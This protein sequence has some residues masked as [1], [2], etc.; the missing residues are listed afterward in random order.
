MDE[1][2]Y[3]KGGP[4]RLYTR[5][6]TSDE[7]SEQP[8]LV[9]VLHGDAPFH[10][11]DSQYGFAAQVARNHGNVA[12]VAL[13]R[14][15]YADPQGNRSEGERGQSIGDNWNVTNTDAIADAISELERRWR[16]RKVVVAG[17][18][19]GAAITLNILGRHPLL[20]DEA[21]L[22]SCPCDVNEWRRH[23]FETSG[24]PPFEGELDVIS[25]IDQ[26]E[27]MSPEADVVMIVGSRD[28]VTPRRLSERCQAVGAK[29][30]KKMRL[31]VLEG[32]G[33]EVFLDPVVFEELASM[34]LR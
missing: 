15:G 17:H 14:P 9:V 19:G 11:P 18:S 1:S 4:F 26:I 32:K 13:L 21:L 25:P 22:V 29:L 16:A 34:L 23:M 3:I 7:L 5:S 12:A 20:I 2:A 30:G 24:V 33:H 28:E 31:I 6:F 8:V 10:E 27:G